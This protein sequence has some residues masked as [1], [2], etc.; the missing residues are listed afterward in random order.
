MFFSREWPSFV[1]GVL[2]FLPQLHASL[3]T[4]LSAS[5][6]CACLY[7]KNVKMIMQ[8]RMKKIKPSLTFCCS[9]L[10][11]PYECKAP[12]VVVLG[13]SCTQSLS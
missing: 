2:M 13:P 11:W 10:V 4:A 7:H 3:L 9:L 5:L 6:P 12:S 8:K 1:D